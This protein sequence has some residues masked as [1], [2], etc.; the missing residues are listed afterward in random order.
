MPRSGRRARGLRRRRR[1]SLFLRQSRSSVRRAIDPRSFASLPRV[2]RPVLRIVRAGTRKVRHP[3]VALTPRRLSPEPPVGRPRRGA[4]VRVRYIARAPAPDEPGRDVVPGAADPRAA[5]PSRGGDEP[6][7]DVRPGG[8]RRRRLPTRR[9]IVRAGTRT[10]RP[11]ARKGFA[12]E[13]PA[14]GALATGRRRRG[15][16]NDRVVGARSRRVRPRG[17]A[18][19]HAGSEAGLRKRGAAAHRGGRAARSPVIPGEVLESPGGVHRE[20]RR[21]RRTLRTLRTLAALAARRRDVVVPRG[22]PAVRPGALHPPSTSLRSPEPLQPG[23]RTE[24]VEPGRR[25]GGVLARSR[26]GPLRAP[27]SGAT[28]FGRAA[29]ANRRVTRGGRHASDER[30]RRS[31]RPRR[32]FVVDE[33][34]LVDVVVLRGG[35][36]RVALVRASGARHGREP[37]RHLVQVPGARGSSG[38]VGHGRPAAARRREIRTSRDVHRVSRGRVPVRSDSIVAHARVRVDPPRR[39]RRGDRVARCRVRGRVHV[40]VAPRAG[41]DAGRGRGRRRRSGRMTRL[42]GSLGA[43]RG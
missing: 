8:R 17:Y 4:V 39:Y 16:G 28:G 10:V 42:V 1:Q 40:A 27:T 30:R 31:G 13:R 33:S 29:P 6:A 5:R 9:G 15:R 41:R 24:P 11:G 32:F 2:V 20:R 19:P 21:P 3:R 26:R 12:G 7:D 18:R 14:E 23:R 34:F 38:F 35:V 36:R 22:R 43:P 37:R 25:R